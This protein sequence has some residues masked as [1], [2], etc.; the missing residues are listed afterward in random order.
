MTDAKLGIVVV[1]ERSFFV[2]D[3]REIVVRWVE[4]ADDAVHTRLAE[5]AKTVA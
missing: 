1:Q 2:L 4:R 5:V 3:F